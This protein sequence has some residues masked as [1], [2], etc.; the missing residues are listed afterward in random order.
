MNKKSKFGVTKSRVCCHIN[1]LFAEGFQLMYLCWNICTVNFRDFC[2]A[3]EVI[4]C[5]NQ[6]Q[7]K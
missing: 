6:Y 1:S 5:E 7:T 2:V 3:L 4:Q